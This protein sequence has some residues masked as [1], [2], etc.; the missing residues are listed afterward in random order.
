MCAVSG[1]KCVLVKVLVILN[2]TRQDRQIRSKQQ[3]K[4]PQPNHLKSDP[5]HMSN[6]CQISGQ[7][8]SY[9][10]FSFYIVFFFI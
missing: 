4:K 6:Y 5:S 10:V 1:E 9:A 2:V 7:A 8:T 3:Q